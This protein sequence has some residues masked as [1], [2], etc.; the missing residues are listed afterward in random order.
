[1]VSLSRKAVPSG[2]FDVV[3]ML[4]YETA[5]TYDGV[6][7]S[8]SIFQLSRQETEAMSHKWFQWLKPGGL[9][10]INTV[11]ADDIPVN[12]QNYDPDGECAQN[13]EW[14]FMGKIILNTLFTKGGWKA[15]LDRAG[16][17][18][19]H[20]EEDLFEP[21]APGVPEPRYYIFAERLLSI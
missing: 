2:T 15:L 3:N 18:I 17:E 12:A 6:V 16:F 21:R 5:V 20:T 13:V 10:L 9:L 11:A 14:T 7:V 8:L 19:V 4:D 1:M